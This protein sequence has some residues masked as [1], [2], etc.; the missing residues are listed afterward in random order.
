MRFLH[1]DERTKSAGN[2]KNSLLGVIYFLV[3]DRPFS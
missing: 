3:N 1:H 2:R